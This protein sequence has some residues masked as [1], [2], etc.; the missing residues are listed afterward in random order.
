MIPIQAAFKRS[1][2]AEPKFYS[3]PP[4]MPPLLPT[5]TTTNA[6]EGGESGNVDDGFEMDNSE[7]SIAAAWTCSD[8]SLVERRRRLSSQPFQQEVFDS[9]QH[10]P[11]SLLLLPFM[12]ITRTT[13]RSTTA[14]PM[15]QCDPCLS[16]DTPPEEV[17]P[18]N[19]EDEHEALSSL[20]ENF[21]PFVG[22]PPPITQE[23]W[24]EIKAFISRIE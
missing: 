17:S 7:L 24:E 3:M 6:P 20:S 5:K 14:S 11:F 8:L 23:E 18:M 12:T 4:P 1:T 10:D 13:V 15:Q 22:D 21:T 19:A 9:L 2:K 16:W